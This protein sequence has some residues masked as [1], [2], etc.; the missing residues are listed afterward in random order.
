MTPDKKIIQIKKRRI[1]VPSTVFD[2]Q[3]LLNNDPDYLGTLA[4]LPKEER[5]ALLYGSWDSFSG[6]VFSEWSNDPNH[7]DDGRY[8]HVID[9][10]KIPANNVIMRFSV[11]GKT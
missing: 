8:T 1:F 10:F 6:Q 3:A 7:Y 5:D 9:P 4:A 11:S 2:N